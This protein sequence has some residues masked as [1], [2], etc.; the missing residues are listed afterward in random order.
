MNHTTLVST[1]LL[2]QHLDDPA[3]R[4]LDLR[5]DLANHALGAQLYAQ[6]HIPGATFISMEGELSGPKGPRTG[7]HPLP[8]PAAFL[9][10]LGA[11]GLRNNQQIVIYDAAGGMTAGRLW[12]MLRW[13]GHDKVAVLDGGF[14]KWGREGRPVTDKVPSHP[15]SVFSG[16]PQAMSVD[17]DFVLANLGK[18][19]V[20]V[21][22]ARAAGR[23]AGEGETIDPV[24][25]HIPGALNRPYVQNLDAE[26]CFKKPEVLAAE[27]AA[28]LGNR[29]PAQIVHQCGSGVS[30]CHNII[31]MELAG[32]S[33]SR[34]YPGSWSEW[35]KDPARPMATGPNP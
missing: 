2:A 27:Y 21:L 30:A 9:A 5:Y 29:T 15:A 35:C 4:I 12:W 7:R 34:L 22:D 10:M 26:G 11:K 13:I 33:G 25:G 16:T 17:A 23:Y 20:T 6:S 32:L 28:L 14:Q 24:G 19:E 18:P 3:W 8:E 31:A 1:D